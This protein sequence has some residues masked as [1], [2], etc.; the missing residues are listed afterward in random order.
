[1]SAGA[2]AAVDQRGM[3]AGPHFQARRSLV[4][5]DDDE[6]GTI[7]MPAVAPRLS[8]TPGSVRWAGPALGRHT[9]EVLRHAGLDDDDD[10][11]GLRDAG[12]I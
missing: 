11:A 12:V 8:R 5:V 7:V 10:I 6:H 9:D 4:Q 3:D 2:T 1:M